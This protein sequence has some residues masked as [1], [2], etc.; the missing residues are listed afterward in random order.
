MNSTDPKDLV[1]KDNLNLP[2]VVGIMVQCFGLILVGYLAGRQGFITRDQSKGIS[3]F[4]ARF[5]LPSLIFTALATFDLGQIRWSFVAL[6]FFSK[7]VVFVTV[8]L[9]TML[10]TRPVDLSKSA[11]YAMFCTQGNDFA[12]GY[13]I[14][15]ML[16]GETNSQYPNYL[17]ILSPIQLLVLNPIG[18]VLLEYQRSTSKPLRLVTI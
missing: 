1:M 8:A 7:T 16:Y 13:P 10:L 6:V 18:C 15:T 12:I 17:Y 3:T 14:L 5:A 2:A 11:I 4:V 9:I